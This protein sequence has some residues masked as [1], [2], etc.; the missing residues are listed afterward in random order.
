MSATTFKAIE[1]V[2]C[3][4]VVLAGSLGFTGAAYL[5]FGW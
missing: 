2:C 4:V 1:A 3:T 5:T